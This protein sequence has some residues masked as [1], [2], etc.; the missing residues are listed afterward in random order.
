MIAIMPMDC[1]AAFVTCLS[2]MEVV[3]VM[4][5]PVG[6]FAAL[7][8]GS[9]IAVSIIVGA[10]D[11]AVKMAMAVVP[12]AGANED[13]TRKPLRT[14]VSVGCAI[15][16]SVGVIAVRAFRRDTDA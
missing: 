1:A 15:I 11:M 6:S 9:S 12:G 8:S 3:E 14:I 16:R 13:A 7:R 5:V 10:I 2:S 4:P